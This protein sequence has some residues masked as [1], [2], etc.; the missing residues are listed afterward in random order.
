MG[1]EGGWDPSPTRPVPSGHVLPT[2]D[3]T[4]HGGQCAPV[5]WEGCYTEGLE[6]KNLVKISQIQN[7]LNF[8]GCNKTEEL[9]L[10]H[11]PGQFL[12]IKYNR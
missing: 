1:T 4:G 6:S 9:N 5:R 2:G 3:G 12:K 7:C 8:K 10:I 11:P